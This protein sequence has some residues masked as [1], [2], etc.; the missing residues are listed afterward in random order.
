LEP[1]VGDHEEALPQMLLN[2][3][4][5]M[6]NRLVGIELEIRLSIMKLTRKTSGMIVAREYWKSPE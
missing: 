2:L 3:I 5:R 6:Q 4:N 1:D